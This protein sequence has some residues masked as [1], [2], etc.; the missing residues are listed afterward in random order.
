M[1]IY[2]KTD[3]EFWTGRTS[4]Q[5]EYIY[6]IVQNIDIADIKTAAENSKNFALIGYCVDE[7]V[8][9]NQGRT[10]AALAPDSIRTFLGRLALHTPLN[11]VDVGNIYI[12]NHNLEA[13][14]NALAERVS[15][16]LAKNYL[17]IVLGGG[18]DIAF[19]HFKG[20]Y[21]Q[22][23][24]KKIGI[25]NFDAH[26]DLRDISDLP[27]SG[28]PF[29]QI[30]HLLKEA[31]NAFNYLCLGIRAEANTKALF[32]TAEALS[33]SYILRENFTLFYWE[34]IK[35]SIKNFIDDNDFIYVTIDMDGFSSAYAPGVSA[36]SPMGFETDVFFKSFSLIHQSKKMISV[37]I[38]ELNPKYDID[39]HTARLAASIVWHIMNG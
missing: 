29:L 30:N 17:P 13:V 6:Q 16:L 26:F 14:Q 36:P 38:A 20:I 12:D 21:R 35:Q 8:H 24:N 34:R 22:Y 28:T 27:N 31:K 10:G 4:F 2:K 3:N 37:D 11:L 19:G 33:V 25:I 18:H 15:A 1:Y 7:G 32:D 23:P 9:R 39:N 5:N